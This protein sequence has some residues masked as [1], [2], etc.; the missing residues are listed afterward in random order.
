MVR[1]TCVVVNVSSVSDHCNNIGVKAGTS[2]QPA[3]LP[4]QPACLVSLPACLPCFY[5]QLTLLFIEVNYNM[6]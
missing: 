2:I 4:C 3:R 1:T 5:P 6:P